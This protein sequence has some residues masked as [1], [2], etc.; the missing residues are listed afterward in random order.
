MAIKSGIFD[1]GPNNE[2]QRP[3]YKKLKKIGRTPGNK[4]QRG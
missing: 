4:H 1:A 3:Q 2:I